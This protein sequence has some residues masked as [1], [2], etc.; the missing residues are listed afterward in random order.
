MGL[1]ENYYNAI[2]NQELMANQKIVLGRSSETQN[3]ATGGQSQSGISSQQSLQAAYDPKEIKMPDNSAYSTLQT[4]ASQG[5]QAVATEED[6]NITSLP[7]SSDVSGES[8]ASSL[9]NTV[10]ELRSIY[11]TGKTA[12]ELGGKVI[13]AL[14]GSEIGAAGAP[15]AYT[16][17]GLESGGEIGLGALNAAPITNFTG[18]TGA[19]VGS[20]AAAA[21]G[22]SIAG[23]ATAAMA[24]APYAAAGYIAAKLG[25][26]ALES[27]AGGPESSNT[28][29]QTGRTIQDPFQDP[30]RAWGNELGI[31]EDKETGDSTGVGTVMDIFNPIGWA[32]SKVCII[33]TACTSSDSE[34]VNIARKYRD[35][36]LTPDE[37]RG[38]YMIA[39]IVVPLINKY[40]WIRKITKNILV[41]NLIEYGRYALEKTELESNY[42]DE[43]VSVSL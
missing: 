22:A 17:L 1:I 13:G 37:L 28:F 20:E 38:Y 36:F 15:I 5:R 9:F 14:T 35:K 3:L 29:A 34:E 39:E 4:N 12:Y 30:A 25:G 21:S 27:V 23:G 41:D 42:C 2:K 24:A 8:S 43:S 40:K 11:N 7:I 31:T 19:Y 32:F 16:G 26:K 10:Q 6:S 33:V 18:T